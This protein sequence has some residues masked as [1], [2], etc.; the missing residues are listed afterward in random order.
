MHW[1]QLQQ[2][3]YSNHPSFLL[4]LSDSTSLLVE[5]IIRIVP[6]KRLLAIGQWD[7]KTVI[8]KLFYHSMKSKKHFSKELKG[9]QLLQKNNIPTAK[10]Y[11]ANISADKRIYVL[12]LEF[13]NDAQSLAEIWQTTASADF[14]SILQLMTLELATQHVLGIV[15]HDLHLNN[16]LIKDNI[17][18]TLDGGELHAVPHILSIAESTNNLAL[19]LSQF[20]LTLDKQQQ[21][22]LF[23]FYAQARGWII[24]PQHINAFLKKIH[25]WHQIRKKRFENKIFRN[26]SQYLPLNYRTMRAVA[27]RTYIATEL[28]TILKNPENAFKNASAIMLKDGHS[29]TVIKITLDQKEYVI[30]RYNIKNI[31]HF[32]RRML[33]QTRAAFNWQIANKLILFGLPTAQP[34][35]YIE[36]HFLGLKSTSY[37]I[38]EYVQAQNLLNYYENYKNKTIDL[39]VILKNILALIKNF[40]HLKMCHGDLKSTNIL[41]TPD[42]QICFIDLDGAKEFSSSAQAHKNWQEDLVRFIKNFKGDDELVQIIQEELKD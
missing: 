38:S 42:H 13:I 31:W 5:K 16:F 28:E 34:V 26:S 32:L 19:F 36:K 10:I 15:Q 18:Y 24:S 21:I 3:A 4:N 29:S 23:K 33:R 37:Y 25:V 39:H 9:L 30:K 40:K 17:I 35:A 12:L 2:I 7:N 27:N 22:H 41:I 1:Q 11:Y 20:G 6:K 8:A 14:F